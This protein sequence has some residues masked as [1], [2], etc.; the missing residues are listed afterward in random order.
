MLFAALRDMQWRSRR[1][2]I[3][4]VSTGLV[5]AMTLVLTGL[6]NGF[7][8]EAQRTVDSIGIDAFVVKAGAAGPFLG[9][10][11]FAEAELPR[12]AAEP[13]VVAA[14]PLACA[15]STV[16]DGSS[17]RNV[18]AFGAQAD[19]PGMPRVSEGRAPSTPDEVAVS[20]TLDRHVGD[21]IQVGARILKIVGIVPNSTS[22]AKMPNVFLTTTGLQ[23]LAYNG[24]PIISSIAIQGTPRQLPDGYQTVDR[25]AG[26][27]DLMR[28]V[29]VAGGSITIVA[30][31]LW[32][33]AVLIV[34]SVVY[35][36]ALERLRDFAV[37][38]AI[39][40]P[41]RSI[42][43]GLAL[44]AVVVALLAAVLGALFSRLL[45]PLFPL[46]V[47]VPLSAYI[48]LPLIATVV[49]LLASLA[50]FRRAVAVDPALAFGGP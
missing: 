31:L 45:A 18:T 29:K 28:A 50:G 43:G 32:I 12:V 10:T 24:Q 39:G 25:A 2:V 27:A 26:V 4:V 1:L 46:L 33:V 47:V 19:G 13:G 22:L 17:A 7:H 44:Q 6:A 35:L 8:V 40:V 21:G 38:K 15:P 3:A 20:S 23:Q 9:A 30:V 37:F 36:S 42:L 41:A 34:G 5:F 48:W 14:A 16:R 49:G 11:P